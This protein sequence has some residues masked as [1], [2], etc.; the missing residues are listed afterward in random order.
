MRPWARTDRGRVLPA[1]PPDWVEPWPEG[2]VVGRAAGWDD[3]VVADAQ[4]GASTVRLAPIHDPRWREPRGRAR[5]LAV[6][7]RVWRALY[8]D[9]WPVEHLPLAAKQ[10][11][12]AARPFV[13]APASGPRLPERARLAGSVLTA[14]AATA[15][16]APT[17][18]WDRRPRPT[19]GRRRR[20]LAQADLPTD[21]RFPARIRATARVT[22]HLPKG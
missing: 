20:V 9:R 5:P 16:A 7:A 2:A 8:R 19:P 18:V 4:P 12:G 17:G 14:A 22:A 1:T 3:L 6:P 11:M 13:S 15:P 10:L 21:L